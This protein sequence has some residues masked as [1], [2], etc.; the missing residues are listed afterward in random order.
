[1]KTNTICFIL[2]FFFLIGAV[3]AA[4]NENETMTKM[5]KPETIQDTDKIS[6]ANIDDE[7]KAV[8]VE[9]ENP[10]LKATE[11]KEKLTIK[12]PN[13]KMHYKDGSKFTVTVKDKNKK[14]VNKL[15]VKIT[16]AGKTYEKTTDTKGKATLNLNLKSGTYNVVTL[17]SGTIKYESQSVKSMVTIKS[18]IKCG[19][20]SKYYKNPS[21]YYSTFY[22]S[23]GKLLKNTAVKLKLGTKT[24]SVKT[25]DKGV[26]KLSV[27]LKP[28]K[29]SITSTNPKTTESITKSITINS[30]IETK[31]LTMNDGDASKFNVKI[32][33]CYGKASPN[34]KVTLKVN[35][36]TYTKTTDKNGIAS[37]PI[38][39]DVGKYT[40]TTEYNGLKNTNQI[41]VN[42]VIK[43]TSFSH[44]TLIPNYVNVTTQYVFHN[45]AYSLKTGVNG[46]IRM[47]KNELF[48]IQISET[49]AYLFSQAEIQGAN[50]TVIG[51][52]THLIPFDGSGVKSDYNKDNLKGDGILISASTNYTQIEYR[53]TTEA[54]TELFGMYMDKG[55]EHSEVITYLQNNKIKAKINIYTVNYDEFGLKYNLAKFY[56][57]SV[58]DFN[59]KSYDEMT[60]NNAGQIKFAN[61][62]EPVTFS[63]FGSSIV[64][65][66]SKEDIITKFFVN[67]TEE[68]E[69]G[70]TISYGL[71]EKYRKSVGFEVLQTYTIINEK[72]T[73]DILEWWIDKNSAYL[74]KFGIMNVYG[75][76]LAGLETAWLADEIAN[77]YAK[78]YGVTWKRSN[79]A[80]ILGGINLEDTYLNVLNADMGMK[81]AGTS[82]NCEL[83]RFINSLNLPNIE[84]YVLSP[85]A[86]RFMDNTTNSLENVLSSIANGNFSIAELGEM[87]YVFDGNSSAIVLN[88]TSGVA[89][90]ILSHDNSVYKGSQIHTSEDC[91][92]VGIMPKDILKG[93][94]DTIKTGS[95]SASKLMDKIHPLS[96]LAYKGIN[97]I[98][99]KVLSGASAAATGLFTTMILLQEGGVKYRDTMISEND[100]HTAMDRITFT[101]PGYLQSKKIYNIPN[102]NGGYDYI[103]VNI[104]SDLTL[105]RTSAKYISNGKTKTLTREETYQYFTEE[106]WTPINMPAK[107]W[108]NSWKGLK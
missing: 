22:D 4:N 61:T 82:K 94:R 25:N 66:P 15:K 63:Y 1:M 24:Y 69:K 50:T 84:D 14:A 26:A 59:Y 10:T 37:L 43:H 90:V 42:K 11:K 80:T 89:N 41:T 17:F 55:A 73:K 19:D 40:I 81:V 107:Y 70:E 103:E 78:E 74:D 91:C 101:R 36:K 83:F 27:D 79:T 67:G 106:T 62:N 97:F 102:K 6:I 58:Y 105:N 23:K 48:T 49:K 29:Y 44:I 9:K 71:S 52:K 54:N 72:M 68:L 35:E 51:Y 95:K 75:M 5:M 57:K 31:D 33:N 32:L 47:P 85:V 96:I 56:G 30:L 104:N 18:T 8:N 2:L 65:Y 53:S 86:D 13:V 77:D 12:A 3:S 100:W 38:D 21:A 87:M 88:T 60:N 20:L 92:G 28:G 16:L 108:D 93:I 99:T 98:L 39:L 46:I 64:G 34:K 45:S 76:F 7:L